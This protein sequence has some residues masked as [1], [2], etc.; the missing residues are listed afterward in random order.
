MR[1]VLYI[2]GELQDG[3]AEWMAAVGDRLRTPSG[4][5]IIEEGRPNDALYIVLDGT[6]TATVTAQRD[7]E[8]GVMTRGTIAGEMSFVDGLPPS[9][10]VRARED[11]VVLA[12][13]R[14]ALETRLRED[15][16][17]AARFYKA[18]AMLLAERLR[19]GNR[20]LVG[21]AGPVL[22]EDVID[23]DEMDPDSLDSLY[24]AGQRFDRILRRLDG[25][26]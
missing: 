9:A 4:T 26:P 2:L 24:L 14:G 21:D 19:A 25:I 15:T 22:D 5:T 16:G 7:Q 3:D 10:T 1:S 6:L 11:A 12:I 13:P 20:L 8:V 18:L 23:V 17:F